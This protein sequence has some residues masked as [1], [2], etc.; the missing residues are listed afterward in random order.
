MR[1]TLEA[2]S[3]NGLNR[4]DEFYS[5]CVRTQRAIVDAGY[6]VPVMQT[7]EK[8]IFLKEDA[9]SK[10]LLPSNWQN[11]TPI[12][13]YGD[14]NCLYR[15]VYNIQIMYSSEVEVMMDRK[16]IL[17]MALILAGVIVGYRVCRE[18]IVSPK[19]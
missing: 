13:C 5:V 10:T 15:Y 8:L 3:I 1:K 9:F 7:K 4:F 2:A 19:V 11:L 12:Q 18:H 17:S 14:G 16:M 6:E